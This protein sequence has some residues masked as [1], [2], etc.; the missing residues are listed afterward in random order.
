MDD[1]RH[2]MLQQPGRQDP[3]LGIHVAD[4]DPLAPWQDGTSS[5]QEVFQAGYVA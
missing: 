4:P 3:R 1:I 2:E 5:Y